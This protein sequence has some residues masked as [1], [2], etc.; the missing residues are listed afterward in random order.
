MI[1]SCN[2]VSE[3]DKQ[4]CIH[5][6]RFYGV[7]HYSGELGVKGQFLQLKYLQS[8]YKVL[9]KSYQ[10]NATLDQYKIHVLL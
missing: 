8:N 5:R 1:H 9:L 7:L 3:N 2:L 4:M 6:Y 10:L